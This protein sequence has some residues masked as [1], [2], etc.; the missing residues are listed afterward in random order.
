MPTASSVGST[1]PTSGQFAA[2][3]GDSAAPNGGGGLP[4]GLILAVALGGLLVAG[5]VLRARSR[6]APEGQEP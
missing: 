4:I 6:S 2:A 3:A 1:T 5:G